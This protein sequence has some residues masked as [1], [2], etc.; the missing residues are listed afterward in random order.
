M[1]LLTTV[2][3]WPPVEWPNSALNWFCKQGEFR[4]GFG[5]DVNQRAGD[6]LVVVVHAFDREVV[7]HGALA[8][9]RRAGAL[10]DAAVTGYA[11]AQQR[12][13]QRAEQAVGILDDRQVHDLGRFEGAL[14]LRRGRI[15][16]RGGL[17]TRQPWRRPRPP[18][19]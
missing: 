7:V 13:V 17:A 3:N 12:E 18:A 4:G 1:P 9:D 16:R 15:D 2:L 10:A 6:A 8:A 19:G 5:G 14:H 11:G